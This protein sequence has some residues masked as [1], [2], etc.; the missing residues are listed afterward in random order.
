MAESL[1]CPQCGNPCDRDE[2]DIG[3]GI[4][5]GPGSCQECGWVEGQEVKTIEELLAMGGKFYKL[6]EESWCD[7]TINSWKLV[8]MKGY[9]KQ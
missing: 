6:G 2:V 5:Y 7:T 1:T 8:P 9:V 4:Q 3:V